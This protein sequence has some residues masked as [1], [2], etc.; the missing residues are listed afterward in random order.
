MVQFILGPLVLPYLHL[1]QVSRRD[2]NL[3]FLH[4]DRCFGLGFLG[5]VAYAFAP[6][7]IAH[8]GL[9]SG[10]IA[11]RIL[12]RAR[13]VARLQTR[14]RGRSGLL[15]VR[16]LGPLC[17]FIAKLNAARV[18][19]CETYGQRICHCLCREVDPAA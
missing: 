12:H 17:L 13:H 2:L 7:L 19:D 18:A 10:F 11:K 3:V 9:V 16:V 1:V 4:P 8:S 6:L 5:H 14:V 15:L